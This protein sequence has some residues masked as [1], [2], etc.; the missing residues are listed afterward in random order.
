LGRF[1]THG[2][3]AEHQRHRAFG[4]IVFASCLFVGS[5]GDSKETSVEPEFVTLKSCP[6]SLAS[7]SGRTVT[8]SD[9]STALASI[10]DTYLDGKSQIPQRVLGRIGA[11]V[12]KTD[13]PFNSYLE[14]GI[15]L[16]YYSTPIALGLTDIS[17]Q[18]LHPKGEVRLTLIVGDRE[19]NVQAAIGWMNYLR[20]SATDL[21]RFS[22][23]FIHDP[24]TPNWQFYDVYE[25]SKPAPVAPSLL[26]EIVSPQNLWRCRIS[27][28]IQSTNLQDN[29]PAVLC[30]AY[31]PATK[32]S[33]SVIFERALLCNSAEIAA[34][35]DSLVKQVAAAD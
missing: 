10:E 26:G 23:H 32:I 9:L 13:D 8:I 18:D 11:W 34:R 12:R 20:G 4:L 19:V 15:E 22:T 17:Q 3:C 29:R 33:V 27:Q 5:C 16:K 21:G 6:F 2:S 14:T 7:Q 24:I 1:S 30:S 35:V 28:E 25:T 31:Y